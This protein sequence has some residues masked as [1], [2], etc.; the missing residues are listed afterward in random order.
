MLP[1]KQAHLITQES[2]QDQTKLHL[3]KHTKR[4]TPGEDYEPHPTG[5]PAFTTS[6]E[7]DEARPTSGHLSTPPGEEDEAHPTGGY[8]STTSGEEDEAHSVGGYKSTPSEEEDEAHLTS[9][10][11][12]TQHPTNREE[13]EACPTGGY[14]STTSR[15]EDEAHSTGGYKSTPHQSLLA[16]LPAWLQPCAQPRSDALLYSAS[17]PVQPTWQQGHMPMPPTTMTII[18]KKNPLI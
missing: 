18:C 17:L 8:R 11:K 6:R 5:G 10:Y 13:D 4:L 9:G 16:P 7:E 3:S 2:K 14:R 12:A 15:E 1:S